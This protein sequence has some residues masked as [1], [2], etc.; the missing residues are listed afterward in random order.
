[1]HEMIQ[2]EEI[3]VEIRKAFVA[4]ETQVALAAK[5][6]FTKEAIRQAVRYITYKDVAPELMKACLASEARGNKVLNGKIVGEMRKLYRKGATATELAAKYDCT[7]STVRS[8]LLGKSKYPT[9]VPP[10]EE[11]RA[12]TAHGEEHPHVKLSSKQVKEIRK[13]RGKGE[14]YASLVERFGVSS[15]QIRRIVTGE[16]RVD[17]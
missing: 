10:L 9:K 7:V 16:A 4:G 14:P 8:A 17:G 12:N 2:S 11:L 5:Y 6:G 13:R 15:M 3:V 1:M